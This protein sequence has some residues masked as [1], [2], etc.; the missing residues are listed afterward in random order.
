MCSGVFSY[1]AMDKFTK[2]ILNFIR[3]N[4]LIAAGDRIVVGLS[5]GADSVALT[6]T[7]FQLQRLLRFSLCAVHVHHGLRGAEAD[8]D[9]EFCRGFCETLDLPYAAR[10]VDVSG[11]AAVT[12]TTEEE[13]GRILRYEALREAGETLLLPS[14]N[15]EQPAVHRAALKIAVAHHADDQAETILFHLLRGTGLK[16][17]GGM[18]PKRGNVIRPLLCIGRNQIEQWLAAQ[19]IGFMTDSTNLENDHTRNKIR[20]EIMPLLKSEVNERAAEHISSTGQK[21]FEAEQF[22]KQE[23]QQFYRSAQ[24]P[25]M[26]GPELT[27]LALPK[28][29]LKEK[30]QIFRIYVIIEGLEMLGVPLKDWGETHFQDI[31]RALFLGKGAHLDLPGDVIVENVLR[32]TRICRRT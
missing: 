7:L 22:L 20:N 16:G 31:D 23:A 26:R 8:R 24:I 32:E 15:G 6:L 27:Y 17:L 3:E 19:N 5:G 14:A 11:Y 21:L 28:D 13:A 18:Q 9:E 29:A 30:P 4:E 2:R 12:G 10:H 1:R 25:V